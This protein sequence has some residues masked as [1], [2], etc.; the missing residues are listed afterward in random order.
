MP[1]DP[2]RCLR[3]NINRINFRQNKIIST[4][5]KISFCLTSFLQSTVKCRTM[6]PRNS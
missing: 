1:D 5:G 4:E 2:T 6:A 3:Y